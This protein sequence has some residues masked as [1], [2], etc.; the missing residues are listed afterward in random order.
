MEFKYEVRPRA[1]LKIR[2][3]YQNVAKKYRHTYDEEDLIRNIFDALFK[4]HQIEKILLRRKPTIARWKKQ[5]WHMANTDK[6]YY[7]YTVEGDTITIQDACHT[8]NMHE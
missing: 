5:G 3:F 1:A 6:W 7:A 8:Q 4:I 2:K